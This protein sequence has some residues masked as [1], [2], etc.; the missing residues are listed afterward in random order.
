MTS[1]AP[2][3]HQ[4]QSP[5]ASRGDRPLSFYDNL[6]NSSNGGR[7]IQFP[8]IQFRFN[9]NIPD[10]RSVHSSAKS[11]FFGLS[12]APATDRL[13]LTTNAEEETDHS[14]TNTVVSPP[15]NPSR[16]FENG[17]GG[18]AG[19]SASSPTSSGGSSTAPMHSPSVSPSSITEMATDA[20]TSTPRCSRPNSTIKTI[21][22]KLP[23]TSG[24]S[25]AVYMTTTV[26][27]NFTK[28]ANTLIGRH[29]PTRSSLRHSRMLVVNKAIPVRYPPGN[30]LNLRH[31]RL[32]RTL[33]ILQILIGL[34]LNTIGLAIM[35]WSPSTNTKDNPYWSG[36]ILILCG[37]LFLVLFQFKRGRTGTDKGALNGSRMHQPQSQ[38][39]ENCFHFLR[40]NALIVLLLTIFFTMLAFI[41]A[42]IHATNL[43]AAGLRC[44][45][46]F[47]FNVNSSTCVCTIDTRPAS[48]TA[49]PMVANMTNPSDDAGFNETLSGSGSGPFSFMNGDDSRVPEGVIRLEYRDFNCNE[50]HSIWYYVMIVS[51]LL[52]SIG[53]LLA[54]IFLVIYSI[55]CMRR[56]DRQS[57]RAKNGET[58][59]RMVVNVI[60]ATNNPIPGHPS[61]PNSVPDA[62]TLPLLTVATQTS[63]VIE[64]PDTSMFSTNS[65]NKQE[66]GYHDTT[67]EEN[68]IT[69]LLSDEEDKTLMS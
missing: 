40:V 26:P 49:S 42:L 61:A 63:R 58:G 36:L 19:A 35:V 10:R 28:N 9:E 59:E 2:N 31:L 22:I 13:S 27:Q 14:P 6:S 51:T 3:A 21:T 69:T 68:T 38:W 62:S 50:V 56:S 39:H 4:Q 5:T 34:M 46:Q 52:N 23:D 37:V 53:C 30:S 47:T 17:A 41:Y 7:T 57:H 11:D 18:I 33:M 60:T 12:P 67:V 24:P 8:D 20:T 1:S 66:T 48:T 54:T 45:P 15:N 29:K 25:E 16:S 44:E 32:C 55:E 64:N 43:S 65:N